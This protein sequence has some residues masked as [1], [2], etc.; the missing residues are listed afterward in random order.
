MNVE[1]PMAFMRSSISLLVGMALIAALTTQGQTI[2]GGWKKVEP[3]DA[4]AELLVKAVGNASA[5]N[6]DV[7]TTAC[8]LDVEG[9]ETQTVSGTNYKFHVSGCAVES[10]D[11][12]GVCND[13][14]CES[15]KYDIVVYSQP[16]TNTLEVSSV[17]LAK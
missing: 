2:L 4:D 12:L 15:A 1:S 13:R 3:T 17:T 16:W 11:E 10:D 7:T 6:E 14:N 5:Y 8:L 9:L